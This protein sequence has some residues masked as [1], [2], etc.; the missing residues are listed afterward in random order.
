MNECKWN[1]FP[2]NLH[3]CI[4]NTFSVKVP[5]VETYILKVITILPRIQSSDHMLP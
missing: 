1:T 2:I 5:D 3:R 4:V